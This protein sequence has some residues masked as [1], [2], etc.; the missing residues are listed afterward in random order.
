[1][2]AGQLYRHPHCLDVDI[3]VVK[4][5]YVG[6]DY[7][8]ARVRYWHRADRSVVSVLPETVTILRRDL[9]RWKNVT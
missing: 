9:R 1:M 7:V 8:R 3:E 6:T 4:I 2:R 5:Q